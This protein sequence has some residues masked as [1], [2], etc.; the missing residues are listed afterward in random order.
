MRRYAIKMSWLAL[1]LGCS[2]TSCAQARSP[3]VASA[4]TEGGHKNLV[5]HK[6]QS[7]G[8]RRK[9]SP[10]V[11][12]PEPKRRCQANQLRLAVALSGSTMSQ[13]FDDISITN[14]GARPCMLSGYP[15]IAAAGHRGFPD[16]PAPA[17]PVAIKV[18]HRIYERVDP[19]PHQILLRP[20]HHAFFSIG[21]GDAHDG[22][23]FTLTRLTVILPGTR[24]PHILKVGLLA[25]GPL[26]RMIPLGVTAINSSPHA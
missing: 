1:M 6:G 3:E 26:G 4:P 14:S 11:P 12:S 17:V 7:T 25:N 22:P 5:S 18:H 23:L 8:E 10:T 20:R 15:Q 9:P 2:L 13:P 16:Q 24:S 19:G 21:T